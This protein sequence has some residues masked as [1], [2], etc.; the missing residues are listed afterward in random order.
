MPH[1]FKQMKIFKTSKYFKQGLKNS[2]WKTSNK[3]I[4][5]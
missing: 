3:L 5:V 2:I 1:F 4:Y